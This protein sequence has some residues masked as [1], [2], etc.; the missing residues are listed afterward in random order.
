[1]TKKLTRRPSAD[2]SAVNIYKD[3]FKFKRPGA[4]QIPAFLPLAQGTLDVAL[5]GVLGNGVALVVQ[6]FA[7]AHAQFQLDPAVL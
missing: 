7:P 4:L 5:G 1:M 3:I 2:Q 6:L